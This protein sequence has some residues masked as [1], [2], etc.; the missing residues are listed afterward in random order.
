MEV[1]DHHG[2][3]RGPRSPQRKLGPPNPPGPPTNEIMT[4]PPNHQHS[5]S[6]AA[7]FEIFN[8]K[9]SKNDLKPTDHLRVYRN[10]EIKQICR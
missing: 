8:P 10:K 3:H 9:M 4:G 1:D 7:H 5:L 2:V 6:D